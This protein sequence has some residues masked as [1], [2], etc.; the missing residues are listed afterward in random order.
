MAEF[1]SLAPAEAALIE[2]KLALAR[3]LRE[4]RQNRMTQAE[5]AARIH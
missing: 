1:L 2:I 4:R 3:R 5:L